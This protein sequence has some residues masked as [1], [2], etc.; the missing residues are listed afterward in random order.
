MQLS[1]FFQTDSKVLTAA[2]FQTPSPFDPGIVVSSITAVGRCSSAA[3]AGIG[4]AAIGKGRRREEGFEPIFECSS[5]TTRHRCCF[6]F[7]SLRSVQYIYISIYLVWWEWNHHQ[8]LGSKIRKKIAI[9]RILNLKSTT[10][11]KKNFNW[12]KR[13]TILGPEGR[14]VKKNSSKN[15]DKY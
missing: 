14:E 12:S 5:T 8:T 13:R 11:V 10:F 2:K 6:V 4:L 3:A 7:A 9:W 15:L 1:T